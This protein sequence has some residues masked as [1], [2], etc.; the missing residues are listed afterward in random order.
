[1]ST[2]EV[3]RGVPLDR[4]N[5]FD[6]SP[7]LTRLRE[8]RPISRMIFF[9][10][11]HEGWLITGHEQVKKVLADTR[12]S[13]SS[14]FQRSPVDS[15]FLPKQLKEFPV[16]PGMFIR[17]D[18]PDHTRLRRKL[19]GVFTVK[20][21]K[22]LEARVAEIVNQ[23]L[24][25]LAAS[26]K[27]ADLVEKFALPVPSMVICELLGVP[28]EERAEFQ[29]RSHKMLSFSTQPEERMASI[30]EIQEYILGLAKQKRA[31]PTDDLLSDL[32]QDDDLEPA[33][34][35]GIGFL[36]LV[37][38]H[39]TTANML[40]LGTFALLEHPEQL[41]ILRDDPELMPKAVEEL[42]RYLSIIHL[43]ARR[44]AAED[45]EFEGHLIKKGDSVSISVAGANRDPNKFDDPDT[46]DVRRTAT[47]HVSFGHGVHQCLGQQL[48]RI[49][50]RIGFEALLRRF[51]GLRLAVDPSEVP[52]RTDMAI[53]GVHKLP[54]T[55]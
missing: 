30:K 15:P 52:L 40:G 49:E 43:G 48:A 41:E 16:E 37:A 7:Q 9:P 35:G 27:P 55:W 53:Y 42:L 51:P 19:T 21:M 13:S 38:G 44:I 33:E 12:F 10:D 2:V 29:T 5:P 20:R 14:T 47:G 17:M 6:P 4:P 18:P 39:E 8:T 28:Y 3:P 45:I 50:M 54:V 36:L 23:H 24:D 32:T 34:M 22:V 1:M 25:E 26:P 31:E 46:L 11:E